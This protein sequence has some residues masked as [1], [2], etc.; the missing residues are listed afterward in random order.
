[1]TIKK[2]YEINDPAWIHGIT[3]D[4]KLC[5]GTV[6]KKFKMDSDDWDKSLEYYV[7][8]I[9]S[10]IEYLLEIRSWE[11]MSQDEKGPI[12][13]Y[14][15]LRSK[16]VVDRF[17]KRHGYTSVE[18]MDD[19]EPTEEQIIAALEK[20]RKVNEHEPLILKPAGTRRRRFNKKKKV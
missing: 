3:R 20:S 12:G 4:N 8:A 7:V 2:H 9:P 19:M 13:M 1:M 15:D 11:S 16:P 10:H 5:K 6:V 17:L 18:L 14:R